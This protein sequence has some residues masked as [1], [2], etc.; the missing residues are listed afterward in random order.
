MGTQD[1]LRA[2]TSNLLQSDRLIKL[3]TNLGP[4]KLVPQRVVGR[5]RL[6]RHFEFTVDV[7]STSGNIELKTLIAQPVTL[8]IQQSDKSY[9][10]HNGYVHTARRLGSNGGLTTYQLGFASWM[11]FLKFRRDQR[12]WQDRTA[13]D[14][15]TDVFNAH[16]QAQGFFRF[17]LSK[18]LPSRSYCR[19]DEDD[20]NFIHRL[21]ES[22]GLFGFWRQAQ[23]GKSHTLVITDHLDRLDP[24]S[25][26]TISFYRGDTRSETDALVQWSG[27]RTL[28]STTLTTRT[29]DYK[30]PSASYYPKGTSAPTM[31]NQGALPN[32]AEVYEYT[33]AYTYAKQDRG[34]QLSRIRIEEW[35][36]R[37]KRFFG[38]GSVRRIDAG[39]RFV[40][41]GHPDHDQDQT[42]QKEFAVI[43]TV[44]VIAN[45]LPMVGHR[46]AFRHTLQDTIDEMRA[47]HDSDAKSSVSQANGTEGFYLTEIEA[48]RIS[49]P[50]HSPFEHRKPETHL[51]SAIVVG[52]EG[53]EV[54]TDELNRIKVRHIWDRL[55]G[56]DEKASC[57]VRV[58]QA[59]TGSG[60]GAV[61]M[62]RVGEE[63]LI[64][65]IGGDCDRPVVTSRLY[66]NAATPQWHSN[67]LLSG[68]RSKE[69]SGNG[70]NQLVMDDSTSQNRVHL[71]SSSFQSHL[72]LGYL[73]EQS[74]NSR[75]A[76]SGNGF[77]L[78]SDAYGAIR[79][80]H[81][82]FISTHSP[83]VNQPLNVTAATEQ[84]ASA[85]SVFELASQ[86]SAS[87]Q[88]ESL[89]EGHDALKKFT[90]AT[91]FNVKGSAAT[92]GRTGG[93]GSGN[94]NGFS[95]P[96]MLIA[97]PAGV[98]ISTQDSA[99]LTAN[100]QI[101]IVS[102][103]NTQ[104]A[105]GKSL[106]VS[107]MEKISLFAQNAGVKLF[108]AKGKVEI[109]AQGD[110]MALSALKDVTITSSSGKLVLSA[111]KEIWIG[112]GGSYI[113]I[114][115]EKIENGTSGQ[116]LEKCASWDKLGASSMHLPAQVTSVTNGCSWKTA[117]A[118]ADSASSVVLE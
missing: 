33:G 93:G 97:S 95:T 15:I 47:R 21:L 1:L 88:A 45:N 52:P 56:G 44:W 43:E 67:G 32:Q 84:L 5:S 74:G 76:F 71:Y 13:D 57:W 87:N 10:P 82:L 103:K 27:T 118:S 65:Y 2:I 101:N 91:Q 116:I 22:E 83:A 99:Q 6:G 55:N 17:A 60:Y 111:D 4:N 18:A 86:S 54:Y 115:A 79:A 12:I 20:W 42:S 75:G 36:S 117:A 70:Y 96:I 31:A 11:H 94:A 73:V 46:S 77:D 106:I 8:W 35:E 28:Q 37:A 89:V 25:P 102:G 23:D 63:V 109:Q 98:G 59:D 40:L 85:E 34:D 66:N 7:V 14:I 48:Q 78:K 104:V 114:T 68:Y 30:N 3:D 16:P 80:G 51:E 49:V 112:A 72:H 19:Q 62:P 58:A 64:D 108:A 107:V 113:R 29:F 50:Y 92:G 90:D 9:Q 81:G 38:V 105:A 41:D 39:W 53:A 61:H 100:Q 24:L 26:N 69:Y 110:A